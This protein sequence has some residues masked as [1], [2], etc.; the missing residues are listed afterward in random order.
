MD[1]RAIN[2]HAFVMMLDTSDDEDRSEAEYRVP[3]PFFGNRHIG[4]L[5]RSLATRAE[6]TGPVEV[7]FLRD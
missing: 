4:L 6:K 1:K 5:G 2:R 7:R 3:V